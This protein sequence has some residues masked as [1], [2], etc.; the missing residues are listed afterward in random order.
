[1]SLGS[2]PTVGFGSMQSRGSPRDKLGR[3]PFPELGFPAEQQGE[4]G[5]PSPHP[6]GAPVLPQT[7]MERTGFPTAALAPAALSGEKAQGSQSTSGAH[8]SSR[9]LRAAHQASAEV[10][11]AEAWL[12]LS[13]GL[14]SLS[15]SPGAAEAAQSRA[16]AALQGLEANRAQR[17]GSQAA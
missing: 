14:A 11:H 10:Q 9:R 5:A 8:G 3:L 16:A 4:V 6:P 7:H 15:P 12:G 1:M 2:G 13:A 17:K